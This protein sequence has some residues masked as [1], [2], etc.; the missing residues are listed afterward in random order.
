MLINCQC[1][2]AKVV[3]NRHNFACNNLKYN[4][5][6]S[7]LTLHVKK[8]KASSQTIYKLWISKILRDIL[9]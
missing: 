2:A 8:L 6:A 9:N 4:K 1:N 3:H 7:S 5:Q